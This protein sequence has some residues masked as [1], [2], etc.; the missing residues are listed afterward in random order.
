MQWSEFLAFVQGPGVS[1]IVG[2]LLALVVEY[3]PQ[4]QALESKWKQLV[5]AGLSLVV[6]L[7][8]A[9]GSCIS[10]F[11]A[12]GDWSGLWWPV[13]VSG[14]SAFFSGT[15]GHQAHNAIKKRFE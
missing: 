10:G 1:V 6:P 2:I 12:W 8:G 14:W 11:S 5:F 13:L 9:V 3:W 15:M 7:L 4:F